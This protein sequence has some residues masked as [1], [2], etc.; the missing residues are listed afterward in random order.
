M[1][2]VRPAGG[3]TFDDSR[4]LWVEPERCLV[5]SNRPLVLA[6]DGIGVAI[7]DGESG[8]MKTSLKYSSLAR[9]DS[10]NNVVVRRPVDDIRGESD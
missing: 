2:R 5:G 1:E 3:A 4:L 7:F 9:T 8:G 6:V 10:G